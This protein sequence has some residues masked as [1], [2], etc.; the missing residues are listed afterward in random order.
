M[1]KKVTAEQL[2]EIQELA[3][4]R[5]NRMVEREAARQERQ[6]QDAQRRRARMRAV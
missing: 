4:I 2:E 1:A 3:R 6:E 5:W